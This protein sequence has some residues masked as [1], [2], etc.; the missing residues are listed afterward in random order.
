[1]CCR[2]VRGGRGVLCVRTRHLQARVW[3]RILRHMPGQYFYGGGCVDTSRRVCVQG[4]VFQA[5]KYVGGV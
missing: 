3:Q 4:R 2:A 1:M 5:R